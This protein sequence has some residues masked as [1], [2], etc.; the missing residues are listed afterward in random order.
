[1]ANYIAEDNN[2]AIIPFVQSFDN[3]L[4]IIYGN[5]SI[6]GTVKEQGLPVVRRVMLFERE[7]GFLVSQIQS[8]SDG[9]YTFKGINPDGLF[10]CISL[11]ENGDG[12]QFNMVGQDLIIGNYDELKAKGQI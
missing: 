3:Y 9:G 10:F 4:P 7:S 11:D 8:A 5:G 1:M 6:S 2:V 12:T